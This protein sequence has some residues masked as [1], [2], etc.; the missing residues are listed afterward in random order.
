MIFVCSLKASRLFFLVKKVIKKGLLAQV[1]SSL[2][3]VEDSSP[4]V[5]GEIMY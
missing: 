1:V 4:V 5:I 3:E 2:F